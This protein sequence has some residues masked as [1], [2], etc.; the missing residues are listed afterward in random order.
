V[1]DPKVP[2]ESKQIYSKILD[3]VGQVDRVLDVGCGNCDLVRFLAQ[4]VAKEAVGIDINGHKAYERVSAASDDSSRTVR[5]LQMDAQK[6]NQWEN[7]SFDAVVSTH[8]LHEIAD[9]NVA[10]GE[11]R[12][13]LKDG[14][15][16]LVADFTTGET[17]WD[18][19]YFSPGQMRAMLNK[20]GFHGVRVEKVAG[21]HFMFASAT[22]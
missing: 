1:G 5:C 17:R 20:V 15:T 16:L 13:V 12:R 21:E 10:L 3:T 18:E 11:I 22:R 9:P 4:Q 2:V 7:G 8:A 6:M 14:G 19:D